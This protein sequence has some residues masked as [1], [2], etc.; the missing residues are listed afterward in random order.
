MVSLLVEECVVHITQTL[1]RYLVEV[2][3]T[4]GSASDA[5]DDLDVLLLAR[6]A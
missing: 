3:V 6:E 4:R 2:L 5:F 1:G